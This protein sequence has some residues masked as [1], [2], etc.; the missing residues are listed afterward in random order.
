MSDAESIRSAIT[1]TSRQLAEDP[2]AG[3]GPD[4]PATAVL[5][6]GLRIQVTGPLGGAATDMGGGV[7][8]GATAPTPGWYLRAALVS[9]DATV[10][11]MEAAR[12]G[13]ELTRLEVTASSESDSRGSLGVD[14]A[15]PPGP[16]SV[17]L[18]IRIAASNA[19][20]AQ[21]RELV[22]RAESRSPVSDA[23]TREV[24]LTTEV[25]AG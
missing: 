21:L 15:V 23:L 13:I 14:D 5:D 12:E 22:E 10:I 24:A 4:A 7:G 9:C 18:Q 17:H 2:Q 16:L 11:A 8:G 25:T 3:I 6:D 1:E 20:E 19:S